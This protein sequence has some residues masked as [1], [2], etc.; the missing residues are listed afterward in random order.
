MAPTSNTALQSEAIQVALID[1]DAAVLDSLRLY[2]A[3]RDVGTTCFAA[4]EAFLGAL[5]RTAPIDCI[6]SDVRMPGMSGLDFV[7]Q[8][9]NRHPTAPIILITGRADINMA[10]SADWARSI[11]SRSRSTKADF[12]PASAMPWR[13]D[14]RKPPTPQNWRSCNPVSDCFPLC[15]SPKS[16]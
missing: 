11:S 16:S 2:F 5:A 7:Q 8:L 12:S 1:D 10:V 6:V 14:G 3:R 15:P 4:A 13:W 9:R